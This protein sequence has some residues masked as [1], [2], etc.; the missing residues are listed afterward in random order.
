MGFQMELGAV[1]EVGLMHVFSQCKHDLLDQPRAE[2]S[3][4]CLSDSLLN[5]S[6]FLKSVSATDTIKILGK[7]FIQAFPSCL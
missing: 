7:H 1:K 2:A 3:V 4:V 5:Q 6:W